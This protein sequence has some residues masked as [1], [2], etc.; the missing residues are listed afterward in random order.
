MSIH[1]GPPRT[2]PTL[3]PARNLNTASTNLSSVIRSLTLVFLGQALVCL[4]LY[5]KPHHS[6]SC[7]KSFL[8][9]ASPTS[10]HK[11]LISVVHEAHSLKRCSLLFLPFLHHQ[12]VSLSVH[13]HLSFRKGAT[14]AWLLRS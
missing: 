5:P 2:S 10:F 9:N 14:I 7:A 11:F 3:V 6:L 13:R 4:T 8:P 1:A 12:Q